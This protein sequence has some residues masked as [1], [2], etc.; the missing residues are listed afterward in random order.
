MGKRV[1]S[2]KGSRGSDRVRP[3]ASEKA[4][5]SSGQVSLSA[6]INEKGEVCVGDECLTLGYDAK[7]DAVRVQLD[8]EHCPPELLEAYEKIAEQVTK[9]KPTVYGRRRKRR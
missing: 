6:Y 4:P 7:L 5:T 1:P 3:P 8:E 2:T 9:G